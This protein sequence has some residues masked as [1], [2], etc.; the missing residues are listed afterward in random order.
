MKLSIKARLIVAFA[1]LIVLS[2]VI[3]Y[4]GSSSSNR[5]NV[6][7]TSIININVQRIIYAS[8]MAEDIQFITKREKD[9]IL[10]KDRD[11]LDELAKDA[12]SRVEDVSTRIDK[13]K[14]I[15]DDAG[16]E[17]IESFNLKW[18][19]YLK[20]FNKIKKAAVIINTDSSNA[21]A[22]SAMLL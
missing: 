19:D 17:L 15:S 2:G 8:K 6:R 14:E 18:Q 13:L 5:L 22:F 11:L 3:F 4:F 20:S 7:I 10:T 1:I 9:L 21:A 16:I 12:D